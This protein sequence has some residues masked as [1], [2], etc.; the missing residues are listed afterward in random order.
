MIGCDTPFESEWSV[1]TLRGN[2]LLLL[3]LNT[4][5]WNSNN[6][7]MMMIV[8]MSHNAFAEDFYIYIYFYIIFIFI[9]ILNTFFY[10]KICI[11]KQED[12]FKIYHFIYYN[13]YK[14]SCTFL[15]IY[16]ISKCIF[17]EI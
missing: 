17:L 11:I 4:Y 6:N 12:F 9:Y 15:H 16:L 3:L 10:N 2:L 14:T 1:L 13:N 7:K 8:L 5:L